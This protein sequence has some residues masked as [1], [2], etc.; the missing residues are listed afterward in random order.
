M[1]RPAAYVVVTGAR[2]LR[3]GDVVWHALDAFRPSRVW[4]GGARGADRHAHAWCRDRGR[5]AV[6]HHANWTALGRNAGLFRNAQMVDAA[7]A[8]AAEHGGREVV[9]LAFPSPDSRGTWHA[10]RYA[11]SS[12]LRVRVY[13]VMPD[14]QPGPEPAAYEAGA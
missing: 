7:R 14:G 8:H 1:T 4:H 11:A 6:V 2:D 12:G 3:R 9:M 10:V 5:V 13:P